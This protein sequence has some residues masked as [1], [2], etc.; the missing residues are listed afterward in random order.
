MERAI[1]E[2]QHSFASTRVQGL[3]KIFLTMGL[4]LIPYTSIGPYCTLRE[5]LQKTFNIFTIMT[6]QP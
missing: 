3:P 1:E 2:K 4:S 5:S 6:L